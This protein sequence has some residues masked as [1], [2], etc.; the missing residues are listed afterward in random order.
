MNKMKKPTDSAGAGGVMPRP[1]STL[2]TGVVRP[3]S[4]QSESQPK[5]SPE[6]IIANLS[7]L[8]DGLFAFQR[9][10]TDLEQHI[11]SARTS[12]DS[13]MLLLLTPP[14]VT[15]PTPVPEPKPDPKPKPETEPE[16]S[17]ESDPSEDEE[18]EEEEEVEKDEVEKE[19]EEEEEEEDDD[20]E[21][22]EEEEEKEKEE[23]L[24]SS[25][26]SELEILCKTMDF[27]GLKRYIVRHMSDKDGLLKQLPKALKLSRNPARLV[28]QCINKG[29]KRHVNSSR[30][31]A[32]LLAMECLLLMMG[33]RRVVAIDKRTK[34]EAEQ[35]ALAWRARL[36]AEGGIGKANERDAQGLLL[37]IGCFGIP[38]GFMDRDIRFLFKAGGAM[39]ISGAL[40]RSRVLMEKIP[41]IIQWMLNNSLVVGAIDIAY[42]F[43]MGDRYNPRKILTSF[44]H[45]SEVLYLNNT[46]GLEH[47]SIAMRAGKKKHLSDLE[48]VGECLERHKIDPSK[49]L[50][51]WQIDVRIMNLEKDIADLNMHIGEEEVA[52]LTRHIGDQKITQKRK[53]GETESSGSFSNKEMKPS[54]FPNP[55]PWPPQQ[56]RVVNHVDD[57]NST[58]LEHGGTA[59]QIYG[60]SLAPSVLHRTVA[61]SIHQNAV[62]SLA[63]PVGGVVAMDGAGAGNLVKGG[64]CVGVHGGTL[65]DHTP[66]QIGSHTGQL[67][68]PPGDA[69]TY[70]YRPPSYFEASG[71]M[72]LPNTMPGDA[73][74]PPPYLEGSMGLPNNIPGDAYRP[75][76]YMECSK[77]LQKNIS[78][79]ANQPPPYMEGSAQLPNTIP[80]PYQFADTVPSA[81]LAHP[82]PSL[83]W[84]R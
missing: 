7:K 41:Q 70:A 48:S 82:S 34:N 27:V 56:H 4:Q 26:R 80:A 16:Q 49:L 31:R 83:Y 14:P 59:G 66:S 40:R 57:S 47:Q 63:G 18:E 58:L 42:T 60:Y 52:E 9:C 75:T 65:V 6:L 20:D 67:Y 78:G 8:S 12:I 79:D 68:G 55:N 64:S 35:A 36:I 45:N 39:G 53:I 10:L 44:L 54:H 61:G 37:L 76:P 23:E 13:A 32:S 19:E 50:P 81:A 77:G 1:D 43:G 5:Y 2:N 30:G 25:S 21:E 29:S 15:L 3:E 74:R 73:Y 38:Q 62:G 11:D 72:G 46:K 33:E 84:K 28:V 17:F 69:H 22:E 51:G 71:S 24:R